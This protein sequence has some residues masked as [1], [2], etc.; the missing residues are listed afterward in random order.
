MGLWGQS[1]GHGGGTA[2]GGSATSLPSLD[3]PP[4]CLAWALLAAPTALVLTIGYQTSTRWY[5]FSTVLLL[6][7]AVVAALGLSAYASATGDVLARW[8]SVALLIAPVA[9][10]LANT[11][12][13][14]DPGLGASGLHRDVLLVSAF[15]ALACLAVGASSSTTI[16]PVLSGI[17]VAATCVVVALVEA[18][19]TVRGE[20]VAIGLVVLGLLTAD[21]VRRRRDLSADLRALLMVGG[22]VW[23]IAASPWPWEPLPAAASLAAL[24]MDLAATLALAV[25]AVRLIGGVQALRTARQRT[26]EEAAI[27]CEHQLHT[28]E[29]L[30][31]ELRS[32]ACGLTAADQILSA[33][34][35]LPEEMEERLLEIRRA[36]VTRLE[37]LLT[38]G[39]DSVPAPADI[40]PAVNNIVD[41]L[42]IRGHRIQVVAPAEL[43]YSRT[44]DVVWIVQA[45][46]D[47]AARH[48]HGAQVSLHLRR[49][50]DAIT[51]TV[52]DNGPGISDVLRERLFEWG[53]S[54]A[55]SS[56]IGLHDAWTRARSIGGALRLVASSSPTCFELVVPVVAEHQSHLRRA[57]AR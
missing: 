21:R 2:V 54:G 32:I 57:N 10:S 31:H 48:G 8:V 49:L 11:A 36:E 30:L 7:A 9:V 1:A 29:T 24:T 45:L 19:G 41:S 34:E 47:N 56:G 55:G 37:R 27:R 18:P 50:A 42:R 14:L 35:P 16:D 25:I 33:P 12:S 28:A 53:T 17:A 5:G 39:G 3:L 26:A 40:V 13:L 6:V 51:I 38:P 44:D 43:P 15:A 23:T 22:L 4:R 46:L 20:V 52:A